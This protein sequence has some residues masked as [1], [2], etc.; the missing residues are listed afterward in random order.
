MNLHYSQTSCLY[1]CVVTL[2]Y[3]SMN[4]HYS[5]TNYYKGDQPIS[6]I[7]LWIYITLK[8][9]AFCFLRIPQFYTSMN[10]HYSQ[11]DS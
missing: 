5:Q 8:L 10:L 2:F 1:V 4:L 9:P 3:T 7:P 11:T 6:F